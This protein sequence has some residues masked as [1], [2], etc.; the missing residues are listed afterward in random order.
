MIHKLV[1]LLAAII[2]PVFITGC[3]TQSVDANCNEFDQNCTG[4]IYSFE[5]S[6]GMIV[7]VYLPEAYNPEREYPLLILNDGE[8]VFSESYWDMGNLLNELIAS[9]Q[10]EPV[11][12]AAVYN[13]GHRLNWYVPYNDDWITDNW[14]SYQPSADWYADQILNT[15]IP[16]L[17][18]QY[19]LNT[20]KTGIMG[21]SLGGLVSTWMGLNFP[22]RITYSA[23]LSGSFWV[24]DYQLFEEVQG[25]YN[26][27]QMFWFDIGTAEWNY[28][29][30]LYHKL[31]SAGVTPGDRSFYLEVPDGRHSEY[32]WLKRIHYPLIQFYGNQN[33]EPASMEVFLE[34]IPSQSTPGLFFRRM[35]PMVTLDN[36]VKYSLAHT[37][38][39]TL[40]EGEA[41]LGSEGSFR[42][43]SDAVA[44]IRIDYL[45]FSETVEIPG[46]YCM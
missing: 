39:Y 4:N 45:D 16:A 14:G 27:G 43:D 13:S 28:Y 31:D 23:S 19:L 40:L 24:N 34:C 32:D 37:A 17:E 1:Q 42:N 25:S 3:M 44:I 10:I 38:I 7:D 11:I 12:A 9:E 8:I 33:A 15:L 26:N 21:A 46:R 29:V 41:E 18:K 30:P 20:S 35:N 36:G 5:L 2:L 6:N 22:D